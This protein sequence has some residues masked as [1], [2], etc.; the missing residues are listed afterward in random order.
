MQWIIQKEE[1]VVVSFLLSCLIHS[2]WIN[3][4]WIK[5]YCYSSD[6]CE[7]DFKLLLA[8]INANSI[9]LVVAIGLSD[10]DSQNQGQTISSIAWLFTFIFFKMRQLLLLRTCKNFLTRV[11]EAQQTFP[12][13]DLASLTFMKSRG[14]QTPRK[15]WDA[16]L[17]RLLFLFHI[18]L[19][20]CLCMM[21]VEERNNLSRK[22]R[23]LPFGNVICLIFSDLY[24]LSFDSSPVRVSSKHW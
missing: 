10:L 22:I 15:S 12:R 18:I 14:W 9:S 17:R 11:S 23:C 1:K 20:Y 7:C 5:L 16:F 19:Q 2:L 13:N 3:N 24:I 6:D 4:I 8:M 21:D